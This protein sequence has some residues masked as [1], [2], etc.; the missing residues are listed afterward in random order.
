MVK[1]H[2]YGVGPLSYVA[3]DRAA[4]GDYIRL[5]Q[6]EE[7]TVEFKERLQVFG[8]PFNPVRCNVIITLEEGGG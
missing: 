3:V 8:S 2:L 4:P 6:G 5:E 1:V 7:K